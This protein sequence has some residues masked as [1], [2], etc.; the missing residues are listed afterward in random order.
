MKG[1]TPESERDDRVLVLMPT[2]KDAGRTATALARGGVGCVPCRTMAELCAEI[3]AGA[4]AVLLTEEL[5]ARD[6]NHCLAAAL[7]GQPPWSSLPVVVLARDGD[8]DRRSELLPEGSA[9][10]TLI[11]RPVRIR[12]L[13]SVVRSALRTR[14]HQYD[15]RDALA[16][17]DRQAAA[18]REAEAE[19]RAVF[20]NALDAIL[21]ADDDGRYVAANEA[22]GELLGVAP[23][24][25]L[26]RR[27][28]DFLESGFDFS[29]AWRE[30]LDHRHER[31]MIRLI[32]PDG[33]VREAE[34]SA[35]R[36]MRAGQHLSVLRDVTDRKRAEAELHK[37]TERLRLLWESAAVLLTTD[38]PDA[39][40][41]G[42]F[43]KLAPHF[44]LDTY[45]NFMVDET[46]EALRLESCVGIPDETARDI[47]RLEF[48][49]A[50][51]GTVAL[52]R[53]AIAATFIQ[54]SDDPKVQ[55]VRGFGIRAYACNPLL[56]G[57]RLLGTLS[58]ASRTRDQFDPDELEF[59]RTVC[60]YVTVAYERL[61]LVRELREADRRKDEFLALLAHE[62]RN[63]LAP[64]RNGLQVMRLA[65]NNPEAITR[66]Q[67]MMERQLTH[68]VRLIDDL[69]DVSRVSR[70]K[71]QL[72][73]A[74][75]TLADV[76]GT[77]VETARPLIEA[78]KH[79]LTVTLPPEPV[80]LDADLTRL[81]QV[82]SNLLT[83]SAKYTEPGGKIWLTAEPTSREHQRPEVIV[84]V[85]DTGI[86]IPADALPT[87]FDM[88]SQV[89]RTLERT[90]GGLGIGLAL[91]RGLVEMHGGSVSAH[92]DGPGRGST[93]AVRLP[94]LLN[95]EYR[96]PISPDG[97]AIG[98]RHAACGNP[99]KVLVVDDNRD[100]AASMAQML[101]L[102]GHE[103]TTAHDGMEAVEAA[104]EFRPEVVLMDV[105][106]PRLNGHEATRRIR[107]R[108]WGRGVR[109]V[110]LTGWGQD[111]D[112]ARSSEAGCDGHLVKPVSLPDL[113]NVLGTLVNGSTK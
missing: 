49:Q 74:R 2:A 101:R 107:E 98:N 30:F 57:D 43:A 103:V 36:E 53:E 14:R 100:S 59:L 5:I 56:A 1:P 75:I 112:R 89:D 81:A 21:V 92:S 76:V 63:P 29:T 48:G 96:I 10:I 90:T 84:T 91:V 110:A 85:R 7:T 40:M 54:Q 35:T 44:G 111:A 104:E 62:L 39:M 27:V 46:G 106:M 94:T 50:V 42:L 77:A 97:P 24:K 25:V 18:L 95:A 33:S 6:P 87:L 3:A 19:F 79:E 88:F 58:F 105:G 55:L 86:G 45:F 68:M 26:G 93:F 67:G 41:R 8:A 22:A 108:P 34:Y 64:L 72:R 113:E 70:N 60:R 37:Q 52:R 78:A 83:N 20:E 82:F 9:N 23:A 31:G 109:V 99:K 15:I 32:R 71:L 17:R 69:L 13:V 80:I 11:E 28:A 4:G 38:E 61:R 66:T 73:K 12:T 16:E 102:L 47:R 51:C 65:A